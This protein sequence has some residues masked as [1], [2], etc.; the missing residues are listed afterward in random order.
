MRQRDRNMNWCRR[1]MSNNFKKEYGK[2][3]EE[4]RGY[5]CHPEKMATEEVTCKGCWDTID[6]QEIINYLNGVYDP[7]WPIVVYWDDE[8][9]HNEA[10]MN[11]SISGGYY[12]FPPEV[13]DNRK[14]WIKKL[15]CAI[16]GEK[17][18]C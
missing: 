18:Q 16:T 10:C 13:L 17:R 6:R 3:V 9:F 1:D 11:Y 14:A 5:G 8:A 2:T 7:D 12:P 15:H 4:L